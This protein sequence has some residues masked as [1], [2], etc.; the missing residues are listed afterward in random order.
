MKDM[1][2]PPGDAKM[3]AIMSGN[4]YRK[5]KKISGRKKKK[6]KERKERENMERYK[7]EREGSTQL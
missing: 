1:V 3:G 4:I 6:S 5:R 7:R 2:F